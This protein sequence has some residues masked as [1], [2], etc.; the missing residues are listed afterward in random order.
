MNK[1]EI[2]Q[3]I[4]EQ[5]IFTNGSTFVTELCQDAEGRYID[6]L[7]P[8]CIGDDLSEPPE[9]Y[10]IHKSD[11][12]GGEEPGWYVRDPQNNASE[13]T[14]ESYE[15]AVREAYDDAGED[16]PQIEAL[17]HWLVSDWLADKLEQVGALVAR[18]VLGFE[19]WGR[20]QCGQSLTM[21]S[22]L[23]KVADLI[24]ASA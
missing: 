14:E 8:C 21:D 7:M 11:V 9:G 5:E 3:R 4:I 15:E 1:Q 20:T 17:Q 10:T 13:Y 6:D 16:V 23:N 19:I 18:D 22:D 12:E 2:I 24:L